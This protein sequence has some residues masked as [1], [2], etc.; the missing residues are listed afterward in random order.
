MGK[1]K[2]NKSGART[3]LHFALGGQTFVQIAG[4]RNRQPAPML[5]ENQAGKAHPQASVQVPYIQETWIHTDPK[6]GRK[7]LRLKLSTRSV[8]PGQMISG[9]GPV[10]RHYKKWMTQLLRARRRE[11]CRRLDIVIN[12]T[13]GATAAAE[14]VGRALQHCGMQGR[15][16]IDGACSSAATLI[17]FLPGWPVAST[18]GS[19]MRI[20]SASRTKFRKKKG[21]WE[22]LA[23]LTGDI[24][25]STTD[26]VLL[27]LYRR[28]TG[29]SEEQIREWMASQKQ[30]RAA[31]AVAFGL[32]DE[33]ALREEWERR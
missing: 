15:I 6:T 22:K 2:K 19:H 11:G 26:D 28:R 12:S 18:A 24:G 17:A 1:P 7:A 20:H 21:T 25:L 8:S 9:Y 13:G 31:E 14:G 5:P 33:M 4:K 3:T 27:A 32:A 23:T 16:L 30:F 29:R 10:M